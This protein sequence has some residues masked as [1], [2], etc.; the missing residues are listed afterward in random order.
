MLDR[1]GDYWTIV[2]NVKRFAFAL[3]NIKERD[4][5]I[6]IVTIGKY[7]EYWD[8]VFKMSKLEE[9]TL[10][11]PSKS[12]IEGIEDLKQLKR[13]RISHARPRNIEFIAKL[14]NLEE[15]VFEYVS[16]F[17]DLSPFN[18]LDKLKSLHLENLRGVCDYDGLRGSN[19]LKYLN[20]DGTLDWNQP[21]KDFNF[22][23]EVPNLEIFRLGWIENKS[24]YPR[25]KSLIKL[26]YLKKIGII[27]DV[28]PT[29]EFAFI[30]TAL[31]NIEGATWDLCWENNG[32]FEFLGKRAG[33]VKSNSPHAKERCQE[34]IERYNKMKDE[35]ERQI[36]KYGG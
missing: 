3:E 36:K 19:A 6:R 21:I 17:S 11:E 29:E 14:S 12:Q 16:G 2:P 34:F 15:V 35:A 27:R 32:W 8:R 4:E 13:L 22:L 30:E 7:D 25:L 5:E 20:I 10:H 31:P 23:E 28:F 9:L 24:E 26:K 18:K 33:K 1:E